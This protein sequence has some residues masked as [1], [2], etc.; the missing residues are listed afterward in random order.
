MKL[1][2]RQ[3]S[4]EAG[5]PSHVASSREKFSARAIICA[6]IDDNK[7]NDALSKLKLNQRGKL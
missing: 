6:H 4:P 1:Q 5:D 7:F 3:D 2:P